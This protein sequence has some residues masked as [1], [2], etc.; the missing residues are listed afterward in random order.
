M[1][2]YD[3]RELTPKDEKC[4]LLTCPG[5]YEVTP[6]DMKCCIGSCPGVYEV[7]PEDMKCS[8]IA[9]PSAYGIENDYLIVGKKVEAKEFGLE[10]KVGEGEVLIRVPKKL[11]DNIERLE[12]E[13]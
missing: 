5:I 11:I 8:L 10:K 3:V 4:A 6:E 12:V 9:C 7:T 13:D 1:G 2:K